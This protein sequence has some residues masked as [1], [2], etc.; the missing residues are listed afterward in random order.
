MDGAAPAEPPISVIASVAAT[1][2]FLALMLDLFLPSSA[3]I[4]FT[5]DRHP[6]RQR[7]R[8]AWRRSKDRLKPRSKKSKSP[9]GSPKLEVVIGSCKQA[10]RASFRGLDAKVGLGRV[11]HSR[12]SRE[13]STE[14]HSIQPRSVGPLVI[15]ISCLE[16]A[17][18]LPIG[19]RT[20]QVQVTFAVCQTPL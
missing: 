2:V 19:T 9:Q 10:E 8:G 11:E 3:R 15:Q 20:I 18:K 17:E 7:M 4:L 13:R 16:S 12:T 14:M 5:G 6:C 1:A